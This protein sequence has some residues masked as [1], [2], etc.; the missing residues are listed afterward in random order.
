MNRPG[1]TPLPR[2]LEDL[3]VVDLPQ[4]LAGPY[5]TFLL[6]GLGARVIKVE[7]PAAPGSC[8]TNARCASGDEPP[9][10]DPGTLLDKGARHVTRWLDLVW[11]GRGGADLRRVLAAHAGTPKPDRPTGQAANE[12]IPRP[13]APAPGVAG[14]PA[15][16]RRL[17]TSTGCAGCHTLTAVLGATGVNG[18]NLANV[19]VRPT[20]AGESIPMTPE[21][22]ARWLP[23]PAALEPGTSVPSVGLT[24]EEARDIAAFL[25]SQPYNP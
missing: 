1:E 3:T 11:G 18:P 16:G 14:D 25:Y 13:L 8:R 2:P 15:N 20:L 24:D 19:V 22:L 6:A 17:F 21:T 23:D 5:A 4:A 7:N 9:A 10:R 12:L